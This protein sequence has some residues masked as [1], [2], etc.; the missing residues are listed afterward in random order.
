MVIEV[1]FLWC[2]QEVAE[3]KEEDIISHTAATEPLTAASP[4]PA[5]LGDLYR[6]LSESTV[7]CD[8]VECDSDTSPLPAAIDDLFEVKMLLKD[9]VDWQS[10]G[11]ALGLRY[12]TLEKIENDHPNKI[13]KCKMKMLVAWLEQRDNVSQKGVPSWSVLR[14]ALRRMGANELADKIIF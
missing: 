12:P 2:V 4:P 9:L 8:S 11:L 7:V 6:T 5:L 10:L 3:L 14:T 1:L 13:D